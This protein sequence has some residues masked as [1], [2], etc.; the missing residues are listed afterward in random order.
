M[1]IDEDAAKEIKIV[2]LCGGTPGRIHTLP[3]TKMQVQAS[4]PHLQGG[5]L[6][7]Q[8]NND[9]VSLFL[10]PPFP[11]L[12]LKARKRKEEIMAIR[13]IGVIMPAL[14]P[15]DYPGSIKQFLNQE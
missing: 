2:K 7:E 13:G 4:S 15:S 11:C 9:T 3:F 8:W 1:Q 6:W 14:S 5:M 12:Y 10:Y